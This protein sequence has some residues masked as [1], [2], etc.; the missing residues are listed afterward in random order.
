VFRR[1]VGARDDDRTPVSLGRGLEERL[2]QRK[3]VLSPSR[4]G[5]NGGRCERGA[6]RPCVRT[7]RSIAESRRS[8][9]VAAEHADG[10][11]VVRKVVLAERIEEIR[12]S[13]DEHAVVAV[14]D[15]LE[16]TAVAPLRIDGGKIVEDIPYAE[17]GTRA[18]RA[19]RIERRA[20]LASRTEGVLV[21]EHDRRPKRRH[22]GG[23]KL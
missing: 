2:Q 20:Q 19:R 11:D 23:E 21:D 10:G 3:A 15:P 6:L 7:P 22:G 18:V 9:D 1:S 4:G 5:E 12:L 8:D 17:N 14:D 16:E 13:V